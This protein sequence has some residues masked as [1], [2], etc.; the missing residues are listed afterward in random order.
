ML[1]DQ[2][3]DMAVIGAGASG[4][5]VA[6]QFS[7]QAPVGAR[8]ALIGVGQRPA[9]GVAY[10]TPYRANLLNVPAGNMSAF[11]DDREHFVRW[12]SVHLPGAEAKTFAPRSLYGDYLAEILAETLQS[13][14]IVPVD[15]TA[16]NL[17][18][19]DYLWAVYLADGTNL[20]ARTVV[21]AIGNLLIPSDPFDTSLIAPFYFRNP[22]AAEAVQGLSPDAP[23]LLIGTGLT[24][25]DV[26]L[27][28]RETGHRGPIHAGSRHGRLYQ[29]HQSYTPRPLESLPAEFRSPQAALRWIRLETQKAEA[30][31]SSWRAVIDSLRPHTDAIW[32]GWNL[33]Q[34]ASFLRHARNLWDLHRHRMAPEIA[35]QLKELQAQGTLSIYAGRVL[36]AEAEGFLAKIT[37]QSTQTC[38][39]LTLRVARVINCTGP[40]RDYSRV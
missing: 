9:R 21:L 40:A 27:S 36:S 20:A 23:V 2:H 16:I 13:E 11:P 24:M 37:L 33:A 34:R 38:A 30:A 14:A 7:R 32:R 3:F 5:L 19:H 4:T 31:G 25:V 17:T 39:P 15:G 26:A 18:R 29:F 35:T 10:E 1:F 12:L 8:L 22:W 6:T 28:L